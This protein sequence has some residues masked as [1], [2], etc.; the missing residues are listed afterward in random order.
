MKAID[1]ILSLSTICI[2]SSCSTIS[3][4]HTPKGPDL[5]QLESAY[6]IKHE[7]STRDIDVFIQNALLAR[8]LN[9]SSGPQIN[10]PDDVDFYV[11]YIDRWKWDMAMYLKS[12][13]IQ[14]YDNS[15]NMLI[16]SAK[17][18]NSW[19]HSFPNTEEKTAEVVNSIFE[20]N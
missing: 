3:P 16:G 19:L 18:Q 13:Q 12:L 1:I 14:F 2:L 5:N 17:F 8:G 10:K 20:T 4:V 9:V 6:V 15:T 11:R 7:N